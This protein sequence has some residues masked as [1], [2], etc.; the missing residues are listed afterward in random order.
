[1]SR[2]S[3][4]LV[5]NLSDI[6]GAILVVNGTDPQ[7][8]TLK[9]FIDALEGLPWFIFIN[10][11]DLISVTQNAKLV[12]EFEKINVDVPIMYGS[13]KENIGIGGLKKCLGDLPKGKIAVLGIF[14][15]GKT[16]LINK[17]T[18]DTA[19]VG[20]IPGTTLQLT[21][22]EYYG[23]TL[24]DTIG[25]VWDVNKPLMFSIDLTGCNTPKEKI[26]RCIAE[27]QQGIDTTADIIIEPIERAVA[28]LKERI[29]N[30][31]KVITCGAGASA[32]VAMEMAG[33]GQE[34]GVPILCF[35]NNF[36]TNQPISFAKGA[37]E[38]ELAMS[39]YAV[40]SINM[41]DVAIGISASGGTAF[42]HEFL[43]MAHDKGA[44][45]IAITENA[46]TP[47]GHYADI[48]IKSEAK[49]EGPS[50]SKIQ[51]AHLMIGHIL[52]IVLADERGVTAEQSINNM[53][54]D[55]QPNKKMG[56]K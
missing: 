30:G 36:S 27:E 15:S 16:S 53:L 28:L 54:P 41:G 20:P 51:L 31:S 4:K 40:R 32:L 17:L 24:I 35:T 45:T 14:N 25:D 52:M 44:Y 19:E 33:Q 46:D 55:R 10:K 21:P 18:G 49:P 9:Y 23:W 3:K 26:I 2:V 34:T 13:I 47:L 38:D 37:F 6:I 43:R 11:T 22:H 8:N 29:A 48:I 50:S 1:M 12:Y 5:P 7:L 42:V 56:I 39:A